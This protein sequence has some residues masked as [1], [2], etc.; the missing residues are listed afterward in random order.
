MRSETKKG[1]EIASTPPCQAFHA[2]LV[3]D[4]LAN[5]TFSWLAPS[6][7]LDILSWIQSAEQEYDRFMRVQEALDILA[8]R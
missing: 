8:G 2:A 5:R 7:R 4:D 1:I 6:H 3:H